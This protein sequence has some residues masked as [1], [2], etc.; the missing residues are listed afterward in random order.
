MSVQLCPAGHFADDTFQGLARSRGYYQLIE[1]ALRNANI[2]ERPLTFTVCGRI[3]QHG[4]G[5]YPKCGAVR[6]EQLLKVAG[7]GKVMLPLLLLNDLLR[8]PTKS[9]LVA[10]VE[11]S[12][13]VLQLPPR[14]EST[15]E[16]GELPSTA[17]VG[18]AI[19]WSWVDTTCPVL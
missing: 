3:R 14:H 10:G 7:Q 12:E 15:I 4:W 1:N 2:R 18:V 6:R 8:R 17:L 5:V 11:G 16:D 13:E 19:K 9:K